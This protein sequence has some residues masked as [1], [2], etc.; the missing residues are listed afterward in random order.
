MAHIRIFVIEVGVQHHN[1]T[2]LHDKK[3]AY[4]HSKATE[5]TLPHLYKG[6]ILG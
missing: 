4:L 6:R 1:K 2:K 5:V 3:V